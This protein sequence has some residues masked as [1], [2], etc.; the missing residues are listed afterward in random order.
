MRWW[1]TPLRGFDVNII[2]AQLGVLPSKD[3][4]NEGISPWDPEFWLRVAGMSAMLAYYVGDKLKCF[5]FLI[6]G[7]NCEW[8]D[9]ERPYGEYD[10]DTLPAQ[11]GVLP[12]K[13]TK[14]EGISPWDPEF[15]D[16]KRH[17]EI[18]DNPD[19]SIFMGNTF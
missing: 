4:K 9:R 2:P 8:S 19:T 16:D 6:F 3:T 14:H 17:L 7:I 5:R 13:D 1:R 15:C 18:S 11:L 12:S 10:V